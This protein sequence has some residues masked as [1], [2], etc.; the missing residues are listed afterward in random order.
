MTGIQ[1]THLTKTYM[2]AASPALVD[3]SLCISPGEVCGI[4][5]PNGAGKTTLMGCIL[6]FL[7]P[8][9][10]T[11][12]LDGLPPDDRSVRATTGYLPERLVMD[13][14]MTGAGFLNYH[15]ALAGLPKDSRKSDVS[16]ALDGVGLG[17]EAATR[18]IGRFSRGMLQRLGLAQALLN[19]PQYLFLDEP[20][21]GMDPS[22]AVLFRRLIDEQKLRGTTVLL[23]SHQL[24]QI[25]RVCRSDRACLHAC[26]VRQGWPGRVDGVA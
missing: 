20:T 4:I 19:K 11:I 24:D 6:G 18:T 13:R 5:G 23:N 15:H 1:V 21:S 2:A 16:A 8:D 14:W 3:V 25:E 22:G 17:G 26:H 12:T 10:G 7:F 9:S